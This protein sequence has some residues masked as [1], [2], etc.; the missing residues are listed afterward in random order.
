MIDMPFFRRA[1]VAAAL[2][3]FTNGFVSGFVLLRRSALSLGAL[4]HTLLP[5]IV[6]AVLI[7]GALTQASAFVGAL[8]AALLVGLCSMM[9]SRGSRIPQGTSLAI[10][11]TSAFALGVVLLEYINTAQDLE[12]WLFGSIMS[13][14]NADLQVFFGIACV[15]LLSST[16]FMRPM[17]LT[18][19]EPSVAAV[20]GVPVRAVNYLLFTLMIMALM[21]SFQAVGSVLSIGLLVVPGAI[22]SL[23]T[24]S[25]KWL[26]WGGGM[27][28]A[29]GAVGAVLLSIPLGIQTGPAIVVGLG[30]LFL[31]AYIISPAHGLLSHLK[32][33]Q[34]PTHEH[35]TWKTN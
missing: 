6:V 3:G 5:G 4:G 19:F 10:F 28:G 20:Q 9:V 34:L 13:V 26:F 18:L 24:N 7:T 31:V 29:L 15:T 16:L 30:G 12:A 22:V 14:G 25:T 21:A 33:N 23:F 32:Q 35:K 8:L 27:V 1:L 2:I 17:L 11:Y